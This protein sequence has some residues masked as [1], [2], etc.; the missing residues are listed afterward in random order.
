MLEDIE[1]LHDLREA[2]AEEK[3][4]PTVTLETVKEQLQG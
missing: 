4:A 3:Y 1:D 2:K